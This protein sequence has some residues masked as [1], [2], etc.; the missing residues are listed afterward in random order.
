MSP[1]AL[2]ASTAA[3]AVVL[4]VPT[5]DRAAQEPRPTPTER[6]PTAANTAEPTTSRSSPLHRAWLR[7]VLD[8]DSAA[9]GAIYADIVADRRP[10]H[11]TRWVAAARLSELQRLDIVEG[12]RI[13]PND[14]PTVLRQRFLEA[15]TTLDLPPLVHRLSADPEQVLVEIASDRGRLPPLRPLVAA[16]ESWVV[17]QIGPNRLDPFDRSRPRQARFSQ[18]APFRDLRHAFRVLQAEL[19]GR[20]DQAVEVRSIHFTN[21]QP[22][23]VSVDVAES[24]KRFRHNAEGLL[25][26][27]QWT[28]DWG[29]LLR[30]LIAETERL[31]EA[32]PAAAVGLLRRL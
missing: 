26:E 2:C 7:E 31:A 14:A 30:Q 20:R 27:R 15:D 5:V 10:G 32:D 9:A 4:C 17:D 12:A 11:F 22:P 24:L 8:L 23:T 25:A 13:D 1:F 19:A 6:A 29:K 3:M 16:A 21:W 28:S 18:R